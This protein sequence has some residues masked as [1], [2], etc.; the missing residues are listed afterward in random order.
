[1]IILTGALRR[2]LTR[3]A[4]D[5]FRLSKE[6]VVYAISSIPAD[7]LTNLSHYLFNEV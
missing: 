3:W 6:A 1:M 4:P 5:S 2:S 7:S